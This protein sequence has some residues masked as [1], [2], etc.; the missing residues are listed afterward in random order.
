[1]KKLPEV[2]GKKVAS[3]PQWLL[4]GKAKGLARAAAAG[5]V[6]ETS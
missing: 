2:P 6:T 5:A 1:M 3:S 4:E